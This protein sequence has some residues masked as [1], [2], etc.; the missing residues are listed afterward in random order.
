METALVFAVRIDAA[1]QRFQI[2]QEIAVRKD[3]AS[4]VARGAGCVENLGDRASR[5]GITWVHISLQRARRDSHYIFEIIDDHQWWRARKFRLLPV[6]QDELNPRVSDDALN[7]I[8]R[9][10]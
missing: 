5:G 10:C 2:C 1:F 9:R 7:K 3:D 6:A 8:G 4:R